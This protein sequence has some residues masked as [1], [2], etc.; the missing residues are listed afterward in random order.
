L[1]ECIAEL[2]KGIHLSTSHL[3]MF[4]YTKVRNIE[5]AIVGNLDECKTVIPSVYSCIRWG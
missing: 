4:V 2:G 5:R 1:L 3:S